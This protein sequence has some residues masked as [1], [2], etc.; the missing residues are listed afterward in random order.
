MTPKQLKL[1]ERCKKTEAPKVLFQATDRFW[2]ICEK[3]SKEIGGARAE[4]WT[5]YQ[6]DEEFS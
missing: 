3:C 6:E 1:C 5:D 4:Q 2:L